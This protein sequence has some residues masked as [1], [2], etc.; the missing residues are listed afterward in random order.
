MV[1]TETLSKIISVRNLTDSTYVLELER[2]GLQFY[3]GQ[4]IGLGVKDY[5][6]MRDYSIYSGVNDINLEVLIKEVEDGNLSRK[7]KRCVAN[8]V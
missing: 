7:F 5:L 6:Y 2:N 1:A 8:P 4:H 3:P